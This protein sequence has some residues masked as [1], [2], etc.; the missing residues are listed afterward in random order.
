MN[1]LI[2]AFGPFDNFLSNPS[3]EVLKQLQLSLKSLNNINIKFV[4][5]EVSFNKIDIFI[6]K[7]HNNFDLIIHLGVASNINKMRLEIIA[8]NIKHGLDVEKVDFKQQKI[9]EK[10][11]DIITTF[12]FEILAKTKEK[13]NEKV[14]YSEDAG[15]YLCNYVYY[16]SLSKLSLK[17]KILFIHIADYMNQKEAINKIEQTEI[18]TDLIK[19]YIKQA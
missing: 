17:S 5:L 9:H 14:L 15:T 4:E 16:K 10:K 18:I 11:Y 2:T 6:K 8:R 19:T 1:I 12:P 13:Y 7:T 3:S